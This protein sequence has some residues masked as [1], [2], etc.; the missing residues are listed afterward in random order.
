[1]TRFTSPLFVRRAAL[2]AA[3]TTTALLLTPA[4]AAAHVEVESDKPQA[5]AENVTLDFLAE[6][7]SGSA[8]I[9]ELR[10]ILPEGVAPAD[11][12]YGEGPGGWVFTPTED[13]YTAKGP[14]VAV[15]KDAEY[16]VAV[17]QLPEAEELAFKTLQ[18]YSDG[19]VDRWIELGDSSSGGH[20]SSAPVLKLK[21]AAP[22]AKPVSPSPSKPASPTPPAADAKP[23]AE[24]SSAAPQANAAK[25]R[26]GDGLSTGAWVGIGTAAL[27]AIA[28]VAAVYALRRR[29]G[30]QE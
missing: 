19:R 9:T 25:E 1:M 18:S 22:G 24:P 6:S 17:R 28:A 12:T 16:S 20:G 26:E 13:G 8:G 7:E 2:V 14:A 23:S 5:L 27:L 21:A 15:G 3:T 10:V 11:V 29:A 4:P 30:S